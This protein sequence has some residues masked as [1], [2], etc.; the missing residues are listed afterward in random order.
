[1]SFSKAESWKAEK[2]K[3][4]GMLHTVQQLTNYTVK[5]PL[6]GYLGLPYMLEEQW[7][8][9]TLLEIHKCKEL[10]TLG[11][12]EMGEEGCCWD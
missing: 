3:F 1:M 2:E 7:K 9:G 11:K 8:I 5:I 6:P 4:K 10:S 12:A